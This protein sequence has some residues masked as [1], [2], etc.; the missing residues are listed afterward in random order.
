[1][2][3]G[4]VRRLSTAAP[5]DDGMEDGGDKALAAAA[6]KTRGTAAAEHGR[7]PSTA[8]S[9]ESVHAPSSQQTTPSR[10]RGP[11]VVL[12]CR[13]CSSVVQTR[14]SSPVATAVEGLDRMGRRARSPGRAGASK[15]PMTQVQ[16][17]VHLRWHLLLLFA[18]TA[19]WGLSSVRGGCSCVHACTAARCHRPVMD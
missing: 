16:A 10:S 19:G 5:M 14:W 8:P 2:A 3:W 7:A 18:D 6:C 15:L 13:P 12:G 11:G 17:E 4:A 1:M 9:L